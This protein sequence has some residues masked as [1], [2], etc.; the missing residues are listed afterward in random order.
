MPVTGDTPSI[1]FRNACVTWFT[2][3]RP[4][5][6]WDERLKYVAYG[7]ETCPTTQR[8]HLQMWASCHKPQRLAGWKKIFPGA[9]IECMH[10]SFEQNDAYCS[11]ESSLQCLGEKPMPNGKRKDLAYFC[12]RVQAGE[13]FTEVVSDLPTVFVQ[14][15]TGLQKLAH[16]CTTPYEHDSV[17]GVWIFGPPGT[18]KSTYARTR[19]TDIYI[20]GQ[21]KWFDGY[22]GQRTILLDDL[23]TKTLGHYLKIWMDKFSCSGETKGGHVHLQHTAFVVTSNY[24]I[25]YLFQEDPQLVLAIS[26]RC[27]I[28]PMFQYPSSI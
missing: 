18:G 6:L 2:T 25:E 26:R 12:E 22:A 19:F 7:V 10:G 5:E 4:A 1:G 28:I 14:Y 23:D 9:H 11:K 13:R 8:E 20:K 3:E 24:S 16:L 17:R 21:H 15:H 27:E